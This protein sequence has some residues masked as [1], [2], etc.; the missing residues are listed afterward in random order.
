MGF[1]PLLIY[2]IDLISEV[3]WDLF[4]I[5]SILTGLVFIFIGALK[6]YVTNGKYLKGITQTLSLGALAAVV[7]FYVGD[8]LE[9]I[10]N[11]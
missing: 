3:T 6:A 7:D 4:V 8:I 11:G 2:V 9:Q 10:V 5:A 1:I